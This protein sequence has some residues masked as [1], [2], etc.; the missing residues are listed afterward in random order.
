MKHTTRSAYSSPPYF[1]TSGW[2]TV[3]FNHEGRPSSGWHEFE[4]QTP[5]EYDGVR[6]LMIDFSHDNNSWNYDGTCLVSDMGSPPR[7]VVEVSDSMHGSPLSW[8][9]DTFWPWYPSYAYAVPN[10][11]LKSEAGGEP[12][13]G[14]F[15]QNCSVDIVDLVMFC[16]SWL[17]SLGDPDWCPQCDISDPQDNLINELDFAPFAEHWGETAE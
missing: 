9:D 14:D 2:T 5:F 4:L 8:D 12:I 3:Y 11:R 10:I 13:T 15:V 6:N 1:E 17:S 16:D 7:V